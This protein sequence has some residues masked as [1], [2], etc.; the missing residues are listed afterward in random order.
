[1]SWT[2]ADKR[3]ALG[4][5]RQANGAWQFSVWA[6]GREKVALHISG[7]RDR[8]IPMSKDSCGYHQVLVNDI[9][10]QSR[11]VYQL[12]GLQEYPDPASRSQP[13]GVHQASEIFDVAAFQWTDTN[14]RAPSLEQSIFNPWLRWRLDRIRDDCFAATVNHEI[15]GDMH[16]HGLWAR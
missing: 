9:E 15:H 10:P 2:N 14:W 13:D 11:Y 6:P 4:A 16:G 5:Y 3:A 12:D 7:S 8:F 1:M